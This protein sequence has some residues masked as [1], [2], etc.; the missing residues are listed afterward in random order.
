MRYRVAHGMVSWY[1]RLDQYSP[2]LGAAARSARHLAQKLKAAFGCPKVREID[3]NVG[4]DD[5]DQGHVGK[6]EAL[7][8]HLRAKQNVDLTCGNAIEYPRVSPFPAGGVEVHSRNPSRRESLGEKPLHLLGAETPLLQ[9]P[10]ATTRTIGSRIFL[11][12]A[13][14]ADEPLWV[15]VV[16]ER[17]AAVRTG[18]YRAAV[19]AL[20]E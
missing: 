14:V 3:A 5:S 18:C 2:A 7:R 12:Q 8:N 13:V 16:R 20:D 15:S 6:V 9:I 17:D 19:N 4:I 10:P 1:S 11:V